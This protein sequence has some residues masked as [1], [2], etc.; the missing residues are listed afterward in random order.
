MELAIIE[1]QDISFMHL[2]KYL[3]TRFRRGKPPIILNKQISRKIDSID[4]YRS[5]IDSL[6]KYSGDLLLICDISLDLVDDIDELRE[7]Y[8]ILSSFDDGY[9]HG[10]AAECEAIANKNIRRLMIIVASSMG[11]REEVEDFLIGRIPEDRHE[12]IKVFPSYGGMHMA[13]AKYERTEALLN[14]AIRKW[15]EMFDSDWRVAV[16]PLC[17]LH[18]VFKEYFS[19]HPHEVWDY[20]TDDDCTVLLKQIKLANVEGLRTNLREELTTWIGNAKAERLFEPWNL[21]RTKTGKLFNSVC[22]AKSLSKTCDYGR[23]PGHWI[24]L[25][26]FDDDWD[27]LHACYLD[28]PNGVAATEFLIAWE[29]LRRDKLTEVKAMAKGTSLFLS[30]VIKDDGREEGLMEL[31]EIIKKIINDNVAPQKGEKTKAFNILKRAGAHIEVVGQKPDLLVISARFEFKR[32][33][34]GPLEMS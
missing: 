7:Q 24:G 32:Y 10:I 25:V 11:K 9:V 8:G 19:Q 27:D 18:E 21:T 12:A 29:K 26:L 13:A 34:E 33:D 31:S 16:A 23:V 4:T 15:R 14:D 20:K 2:N 3:D 6:R 5:V 1:D 30:I 22:L 17:K 28:L